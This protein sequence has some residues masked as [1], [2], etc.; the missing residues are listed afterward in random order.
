MTRNLGY[1]A[2]QENILLG[3]GPGNFGSYANMQRPDK[4]GRT[5][6]DP[7]KKLLQDLLERALGVT[8]KKPAAKKAASKSAAPRKR[9]PAKRK[10]YY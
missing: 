4:F 2:F 6:T 1:K 8:R 7:E 5:V 10:E 3:V 9:A